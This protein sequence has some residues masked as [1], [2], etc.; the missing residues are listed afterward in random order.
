M[1]KNILNGV[2][3]CFLFI[4]PFGFRCFSNSQTVDSGQIS[5]CSQDKFVV[6]SSRVF[7]D[8]QRNHTYRE[9]SK[10]AIKLRVSCVLGFASRCYYNNHHIQKLH[11]FSTC[12]LGLKGFISHAKMAITNKII[13]DLKKLHDFKNKICVS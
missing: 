6:L 1:A 4:K 8:L 7:V 12:L 13:T 2:L 11:I 3:Y 9:I 10:I 5:A